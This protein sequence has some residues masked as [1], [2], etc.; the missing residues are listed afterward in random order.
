MKIH[1]S[2]YVWWWQYRPRIY[3]STFGK[4]GYEVAF[5]DVVD[6]VINTL[7]REHTYPV[8]I[9][10]GDSYE[11]IDVMNV[12]AVDGKDPMAV[13]EAIAG[14]DI[15]ATAV[16][17]NVLKFIIPNIVEG[18]RLRKE[19]NLPPFN[20]IICENLNDAN[21]VIEGMIKDRLIGSSALAFEMGVTPAYIAIGAA[22]GL[23][24]Y[25]NE[26][27][28]K[29]I[30]ASTVIETVCEL[31]QNSELAKLILEMYELIKAGKSFGEIRRISDK[32]VAENLTNVI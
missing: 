17:V 5:V 3:W 16:G 4:P 32:K 18:L 29:I 25:M 1:E 9:V 21:K 24:R 28:D 14:A 15:M 31:D 26:A 22:A 23:F 2:S 7:N 12:S 6:D 10:K 13:A 8:R 11:D 30:T 27:E 19:R 20:I